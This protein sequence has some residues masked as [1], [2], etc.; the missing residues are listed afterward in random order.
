MRV[1]TAS[2]PAGGVQTYRNRGI[3]LAAAI[4]LGVAIGGIFSISQ[5]QLWP[6]LLSVGICVSIAS[7]FAWGV[8]AVTIATVLALVTIARIAST[9]SIGGAVPIVLAIIAII[10]LS[11][12]KDLRQ[13]LAASR[14]LKTLLAVLVAWCAWTIIRL[15]IDFSTYGALAA[16]DAVTAFC[17]LG[18]LTGAAVGWRYGR[19]KIASA[20]RIIATLAALYSFLYPFRAILPAGVREWLDFGNVGVMGTALL[21]FAL[22][23]EGRRW[24]RALFLGS[25]ATSIVVSQGRMIYLVVGLMLLFYVAQAIF[26][27]IGTRRAKTLERLFVLAILSAFAVLMT[28]II[29]QLPGVA[30]RVGAISFD[31]IFTQLETLSDNE[32]GSVGD[33]Q[34]WWEDIWTR[35]SYSWDTFVLGLGLGPDLLN[36]YTGPDGSLIRKP[37]NDF[38]EALVRV[39]PV[40]LVGLLAAVTIPTPSLIRFARKS[41]EGVAIFWWCTAAAATAFAQPYFAYPHGALVFALFS[42]LAVGATA[43][44]RYQDQNEVN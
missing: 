3:V 39:G 41:P 10:T 29:S 31:A 25:A 6:V 32:S 9:V 14:S 42:G 26:S 15:M 8:P 27:D 2:G 44:M 16:R 23:G 1:R 37:H 38:F 33:R 11:L 43:R 12:W 5:G 17:F 24:L 28:A 13:A 21:A 34:R 7:L 36:G 40:G 30:G 35:Y 19:V 4:C 22:W 18:V 20:A